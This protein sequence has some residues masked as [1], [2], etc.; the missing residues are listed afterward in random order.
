MNLI[1]SKK[2]KN[3]IL[4]LLFLSSLPFILLFFD[5]SITK[6]NWLKFGNIFGYLGALLIIWQFTLGVR[7]FSKWVTYDYDWIIKIHT[8]LGVKGGIFVLA[9]PILT[10]L[11]YQEDV[12]Y[13]VNFDFSSALTSSITLGRIALILFLVVWITS[14][15]FRKLLSYRVWLYVHYLT[16]P[17]LL[18]I[19]LHPFQIG[20]YLSNNIFLFYYW[21]GLCTF[22]LLIAVFK[23]FDIL[24]ITNLKYELIEIKNYAGDI[25][26]LKYKP[27]G[28][29]FI[30]VEPGQYFY[31]KKNFIGESHPF[32]ILEYNLENGEL[33]FGLKKLGKFSKNLGD[34]KLGEVHYLDGAF[35]EF[36]FEAHD[37]NPKVILAGGIGI[38]PF[39][40]VVSQYG[41]DKTYLFY[42]NQNLSFALYRDKFKKLLGKN[43]Y[44]FVLE[45]E[46]PK[47]NVFCEL[48][49]SRKIIELVG[50][51]KLKSFKY[52]ICGGP[53]FTKGMINC[54]LELGVK[55]ELIFIE[56]FEY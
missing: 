42:A 9:H 55:R 27:V 8:I 2:R 19:L 34:S 50:N 7:G 38:T 25:F 45:K 4:I 11:G 53:A 21:I 10:I 36:T 33:T 26:T 48:I 12:F 6:N 20:T 29:S 46:G 17:M 41:N 1:K 18:L 43:Y 52:F 49:T 5:S 16:Y 32:S 22:A 35:G 39:Y 23:L 14:A 15:V 51:D 44:D 13:L 47:Q 37:N 28:K 31:I 24:N 56:E 54:L 3:L 40:E 30:K